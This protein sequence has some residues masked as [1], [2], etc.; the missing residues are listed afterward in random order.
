MIKRLLLGFLALCLVG[1][2]TVPVTTCPPAE[3]EKVVETVT[4]KVIRKPYGP[5]GC[6]IGILPDGILWEFC[7][8]SQQYPVSFD[9]IQWVETEVKPGD[10][11]PIW[12][13]W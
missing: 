2:G 7:T 13:G 6:D 3:V 5:H 1:C 10:P 11:P 8:R 4:V 9:D 12:G